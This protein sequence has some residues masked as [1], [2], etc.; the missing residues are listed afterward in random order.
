MK[1]RRPSLVKSIARNTILCTA[2]RSMIVRQ[3]LF[4]Y[5]LTRL[6]YR[7]LLVNNTLD[8]DPIQCIGP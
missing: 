4:S 1:E 5:R 6:N 2:P 7:Q 3:R 8:A